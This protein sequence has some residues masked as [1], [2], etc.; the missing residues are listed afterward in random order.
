MSMNKKDIALTV[1]GVLATMVL[2]YLL[3]RH[4]QTAAAQAALDAAANDAQAQADQYQQ[5]QYL[6][7]LPSTNSYGGTST[8]ATSNEG[9]AD[10]TA[11]NGTSPDAAT[12]T[13]LSSIIAAFAG[14]INTGTPGSTS[15]ASLIPTIDSGGGTSLVS[16][17]T[18]AQQVL[19]NLDP[20]TVA[21]T[22]LPASTSLV[23]SVLSEVQSPVSGGTSRLTLINPSQVAQ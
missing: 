12:E 4:Q 2:A 11:S 19:D 13:L 10:T 15:N 20:A 18:T 9:T 3:Y 8:L 7:Q 23:S 14:S 22:P 16:V 5:E 21:V 17:P 1:G 6:S